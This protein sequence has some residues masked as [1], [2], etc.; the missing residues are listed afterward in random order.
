MDVFECNTK[1]MWEIC[2]F[3]F[4]GL[5]QPVLH[6]NTNVVNEGEEVQ[7]TCIAPGEIGSFIFFFFDND[8][9][10]SRVEGHSN[11]AKTTFRLSGADIHK[12]HCSYKI[13]TA[14]DTFPSTKS[15]NVTVSVKGQ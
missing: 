12:I 8:E 7:A 6:L 15:N 3:M 14:E 9:Q 5:S 2:L 4:P 10:I 13:R 11:Q 1:Y